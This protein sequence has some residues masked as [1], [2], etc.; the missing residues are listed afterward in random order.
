MDLEQI[1]I[2]A[3][4]TVAALAREAKLDRRTVERAEAGETITIVKATAIALALTRV[5]GLTHTVS[6]LGIRT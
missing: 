4:L 6:S 3:G 5:T 2:N 1:R